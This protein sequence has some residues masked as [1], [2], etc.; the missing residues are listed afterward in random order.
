MVCQVACSIFGLNMVECY[1]GGSCAPGI[2]PHV[3][4][5]SA[6]MTMPQGSAQ[7]CAVCTQATYT[8]VKSTHCGANNFEVSGNKINMTCNILP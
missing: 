4:I 2:T 5:R 8:K 3:S 1:F 7:E 6:A